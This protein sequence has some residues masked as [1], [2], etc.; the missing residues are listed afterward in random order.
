MGHEALG[1][2]RSCRSDLGGRRP[3]RLGTEI[4]IAFALLL[5]AGA[6]TGWS[7]YWRALVRAFRVTR[8]QKPGGLVLGGR[9]P[10]LDA[11]VLASSW[12]PSWGP[13]LAPQR[14]VVRVD[15]AGVA[16]LDTTVPPFS[17]LELTWSQIT[18]FARI[19]YVEARVA[20]QGLAIQGADGSAIVLQMITPTCFPRFPRGKSLGKIVTLADHQRPMGE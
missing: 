18:G 11:R 5:V 6:A 1:S 14:V 17:L 8:A 4:G 19:E 12:P 20:Y 13:A 9:I 10:S 2:G 16:L 7:L 15:R 3:C